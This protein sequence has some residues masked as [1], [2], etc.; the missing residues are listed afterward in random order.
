MRED[1]SRPAPAPILGTA[2]GQPREKRRWSVRRE[3]V[4]G[5]A[6]LMPS[7]LH[8]AVFA[9]GLIVASIAI[10]FTRWDL[11]SS[12]EFNGLGNYRELLT[13]DLFWHATWRTTLYAL[14]V[15]PVGMALS[16]LLA[17]AVNTKLKGMRY[18]RTAYFIPAIASAVAV[19]VVWRWM[20]SKDVGI[21]NWFLSLVGVPP[22][23]WLGDPG[24]ALWAVA[25]VQVWRGLGEGMIIF[26]AG[27]QAVPSHLHEAAAL[28]G[29]NRVQR[30]WHITWP[31][32]TPTTF[33]VGVLEVI[34]SFQVFDMVYLMTPGGGPD[35]STF[36]YNYYLFTKGFRSFEMGYAAA[37][38]WMLFLLIGL[39]TLVQFKVLNKR[40][41]Y[42]LG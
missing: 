4:V 13:D 1:A 9:G 5:Y 38:A 2:P 3:T 36:V 20:Y 41:Q 37:M 40:V 23:N 17:L 34:G 33:F 15:I 8:F 14:F 27:L 12:P 16:L 42:E 31:L 7:L 24:T 30:F 18:F 35:R 29:A 26:L 28:D 39:L 21:V 25:L 22:V 32:L 10:S 19:A 6:F 11:L